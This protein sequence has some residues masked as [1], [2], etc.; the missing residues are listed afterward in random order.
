MTPCLQEHPK[1]TAVQIEDVSDRQEDAPP[2]DGGYGWVCVG[3][4]FLT[5]C[6]TWGTVSAYSVYLS[7]Y[8]A[9]DVFPDATPWDYAFIGGFNFSIA[10][11]VAPLVTVLVR[12]FGTHRTMIVGALLQCSG[13]LAA[14]FAIQI[15]QLHLSQGALIGAGIGFLYIPSL[16]ILSQWFAKKR[17]LANG[18]SAAGSGVGGV[19]FAWGSEATIQ[20]IGIAWSLR[21]T[22]IIALMA[23]LAAIAVLRDRNHVIRPPQLAFDTKLLRRY[24]VWLLLAWAFAS[25]LGYVVLLFS[26]P[27]FALSIGFSRAQATDLIGFL[28]LG[29]TVGR[30]IIGIVSDKWSRID[31]AGSLTLLCGLSCFAFWLPA[32]SYGLTVFFAILCGAIV[33]VFWMVVSLSLLQSHR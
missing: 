29:T 17:S 10:M 26:L 28:N 31:T 5:N 15:W 23:V 9:D 11:L 22:G 30:P 4:C 6:S 8:L 18:I 3:A 32:T 13:F 2:P 20:H 19:A 14:S 21:I 33:G 16:P 1:P 7:H 24:D 12:R 25:M 27:D